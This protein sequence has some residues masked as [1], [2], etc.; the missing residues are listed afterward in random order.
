MNRYIIFK[1]SNPQIFKLVFLFFVSFTTF[2]QDESRF[3]V[4]LAAGPSLSLRSIYQKIAD[5][6]RGEL[7]GD[8]WAAQF[9]TTYRFMKNIGI[10]ARI[11]YNQNHTREE[12]VAKIALY[13]YNITAPDIT[14]N[15]DWTGISALAGP[16]FHFFVGKFAFEARALAGYAA[17]T[18]PQFELNG[19]FAGRKINVKTTTGNAQNVAFGGGG[20]LRFKL[21]QVVSMT[22]NADFI[23]SDSQF[24]DIATIVTSGGITANQTTA[25][26]Q[27]VGFLNIMGGLQ[28]NF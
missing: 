9:G 5:N 8:G 26:D 15:T 4:S 3:S 27:K 24:K 20:T 14:Q 10:T 18:G 13:Q 16:S 22:V 7:A 28:F 21:S 6:D 17:V 2:A 23:Q 12:G 11:N 25:L 19:T 1:F